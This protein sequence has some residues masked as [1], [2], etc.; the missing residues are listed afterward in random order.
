MF[1][2]FVLVSIVNSF[3]II[4]NPVIVTTTTTTTTRRRVPRDSVFHSSLQQQQ[5]QQRQQHQQQASSTSRF[6]CSSSSLYG[7]IRSYPQRSSAS[8]SSSSSSSSTCNKF[9]RLRPLSQQKQ[10]PNNSLGIL[11]W[12]Y[13]PDG[14]DNNEPDNNNK[15]DQEEQEQQQ[16]Q[17]NDGT[18]G[19]D[20]LYEF[21]TRRTGEQAGESER[22]RKRDRIMEW[23]KSSKTSTSTKDNN[24]GGANLIQ[25]IRLQDGQVDAELMASDRRKQQ[26]QEQQP[27]R[28]NAKLDQLFAGMPTL[29]EILTK[30]GATNTAETKTGDSGTETEENSRMKR[31]SSSSSSSSSNDDDSWFDLERKRIEQEYTQIRDDMKEQIRQQ[32]SQDPDGIP[33]NAERIVEAIVKQEM[34]RMVQ[35][36]KLTRAKERLQEYQLNR[37]DDLN[38]KDFSGTTDA[39]VEQILKEAAEDWQ[40]RDKLQ[41]QADEFYQYQTQQQQQQQQQQQDSGYNDNNNIPTPQDDDDSIMDLDEWALE[42]L[43]EMLEESQNREDDNGSI[44]DILE[45]NIEVLRRRIEKESKKGNIQP[46]TMKEWQMYRAIATRLAKSGGGEM[47]D[48]IINEDDID[49][50]LIAA[51]LNSWREYIEK[52]DGI[53]K[54]SGLSTGPRLPFDSLG[55]KADR[56]I[57]RQYDLTP[58]SLKDEKKT[59]REIRREV[60]IQAIQAMEDL[61]SKSDSVRAEGLKKELAA[62]KAELEPRDFN[63]TEEEIMEDVKTSMEPVDL[64][65][66]FRTSQDDSNKKGAVGGLTDD[67]YAGVNKILS[68]TGV[69]GLYGPS[70]T[71]QQETVP[72]TPPNTPFF[73]NSVDNNDERKIPPP[74]N[75]PFFQNDDY[76]FDETKKPPPPNTPF[77]SREGREGGRSGETLDIENKLGSVEEQKLQ[78]MFRR[79][80]ARTK[81][82]QE[83]IRQEWEA[84]Q[85]FEKERRDLSGLSEDAVES[86]SLGNDANLKYDISDVM[87]GDGDFDADK[88]LSTIGPRPTKRSKAPSNNVGSKDTQGSDTSIEDDKLASDVSSADV[89]DSLFRSVAAAGGGRVADEERSQFDEYLAK[90]EE[91]RQNL[92][93]IDEDAAEVAKS[94][95]VPVDDPKYAQDVLSS[96]GSRPVFKKRRKEAVDERMLS[97]MGGIRS[98]GDDFD[99]VPSSRDYS[100]SDDDDVPSSSNEESAFDDI[101]PA[102][103]KK[104]REAAAKS[105]EE[106]DVGMLGS[107]ID[108]M[109]DDDTYEKNL[110]QLH[111]YEQRRSGK[112]QMG[113]DISDIFGRRGS[114]DYADYTYDTEYFRERQDGWGAASFQARKENLL[115]YVELDPAEVNSIMAQ[116]E[117]VYS[118]GVSQYLPRIN[119]PFKE[120][121]AIF[122]LEGVLVDMTGLQQKVWKRVSSEFSPEFG[123]KDPVVE[124]IQYAAVT[125]P[126]I[127]VREILFRVNDIVLERKV[128]DTYRRILREEF[129]AWAT[130]EGIVVQ[131]RKNT[132]QG[133]TPEKGA[134]TIGFD[135]PDPVPV[136]RPPQPTFENE[137]E[138]LKHLKD[139]WTKTA[140]QFGYPLPTNEQIAESAILA[141][142]IAVETVFRW[143][144]D[145][146]QI[147]QIVA[148]FSIM[149]A[150]NGYSF[151]K[152]RAFGGTVDTGV[153]DSQEER[154]RPKSLS[155]GEVLEF[156]YHAW[157]KVANENLLEV[158]DPEEV[159]AAAVLNDPEAVISSGFGWTDDP[160]R[161]SSLANQYRKCLSESLKGAGSVG[162]TI[163]EQP[164]PV[165]RTNI[166]QNSKPTGPSDEEVLTGQLEAWKATALEFDFKVPSTDRIQMVMNASPRDAVAQLLLMDYDV[167]DDVLAEI[168]EFYTEALGN[169]LKRYFHQNNIISPNTTPMASSMLAT[170]NKSK[171]VSSDE[172][173]QAA[174][175][176]W[177]SIAWKNG[178]SMPDQEQV[179]FAM[180]V[181]P[182]Q[183]IL[184][185]F[186]WTDS[187]EKAESIAKEYLDQIKTKRDDWVKRG[188]TTTV[189]IETKTALE[190]EEIPS[191]RVKPGVV[192]WIQSLRTVDMA[193]GVVSFLEAD[194][195]TILLEYAGLSELFPEEVRVSHSNGYRT[196]SQ[197]LLGAALR[198]ERRPDHCVAFDTSPYGSV[199]AHDVEMRS[200]SLVGP[201][202]RY[203][204]LSADTTSSSVD[205]LTAMNI[206][207]LFGERVYDQPELDMMSRQPETN[208][209]VKTAYDWD[210]E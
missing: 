35:S 140:K 20:G 101:V 15:N 23:M 25:P 63:D 49:E 102:W 168:T 54:R 4:L 155:E 71:Y 137:A 195:M 107:N 57:P 73:S 52:E 174:F 167:D 56:I 59:R 128:L 70:N 7:S 53:R 147:D 117:S 130:E 183:A 85:Q 32:R 156:Q 184:A 141:P 153:R 149:Q 139:V 191:V 193:C 204:L 165:P 74:P 126:E 5:Y 113:I 33:D 103:L 134:F 110:R 99:D 129:N 177:T 206:R 18:V 120:F 12:S 138:R 178:Y 8:S 29:D 45:D 199:A 94:M 197:Q 30:G 69:E 148:A 196:D 194:Q 92:D 125:R 93:R 100:T 115:Q 89:A 72:P 68:N 172:I 86:S 169:A 190:V 176:A 76:N 34:E 145:Q 133:K 67:V 119:K 186:Q 157:K 192:D 166:D 40:R 17:D 108:E 208:R 209:R 142:D 162:L 84:F 122:R 97:D 88:I 43:E 150:G 188:Y 201:Y 64:S 51:R 207:R 19:Y 31:S 90:Q 151:S 48:T 112:K 2:L 1:T 202:P 95:D 42:R 135:E 96:I 175:D 3:H 198:I 38:A 21:L 205:E 109:F 158:P 127:A 47:G 87:K 58:P 144:S 182:Q 181:G 118:T 81:A 44:S 185:G 83:K 163:V 203:E 161:I 39:V 11:V 131:E 28:T 78:A 46:K 79:A 13:P 189:A 170:D 27:F 154:N 114:D 104:E 41:A 98:R 143:S 210:D 136:V 36:V 61:I 200:V 26:Q 6:L 80:G 24:G 132:S 164:P 160:Q 10:P 123:V 146:I 179:Q 37:M 159:L 55:E 105:R 121:G 91:L 9:Q 77:F 180:T 16:Q 152:D 187:E 65:D 66:V 22:Q 106:S 75:T 111:E 82:E 171:D 50:A 124:D 60:N 62:L 173:Y 116:K 14:S